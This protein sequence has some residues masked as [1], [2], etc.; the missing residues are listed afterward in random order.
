MDLKSRIESLQGYCEPGGLVFR[1][2][3]GATVALS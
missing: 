3:S 2:F 1:D